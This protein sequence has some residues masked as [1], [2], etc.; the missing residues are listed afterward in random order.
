MHAIKNL[1][2]IALVSSY[3]MLATGSLIAGEKCCECGCHHELKKVYRPVVTFKECKFECWDYKTVCEK[4]LV[5]TV[6]CCKS[7]GCCDGTCSC[8]GKPQEMC[9][10]VAAPYK[11]RECVRKIP[12]VTWVVECRCKECCNKCKHHH[13]HHYSIGKSCPTCD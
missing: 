3:V 9:V 4:V 8:P 12:V 2:L 1:S 5:P 10:P 11:C 6:T 13:G 7:C